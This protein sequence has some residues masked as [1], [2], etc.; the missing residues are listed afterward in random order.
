MFWQFYVWG[1]EVK[2]AKRLPHNLG[3]KAWRRAREAS[4]LSS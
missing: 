1:E 2:L 3:L 4:L